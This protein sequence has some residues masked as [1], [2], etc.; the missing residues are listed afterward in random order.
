MAWVRLL[1]ERT[2]WQRAQDCQGKLLKP[3]KWATEITELWASL[4][5]PSRDYLVL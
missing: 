4:S 5:G 1:R 2:E 3:W